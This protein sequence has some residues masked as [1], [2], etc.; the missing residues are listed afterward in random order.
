MNWFLIALIAPA[1]WSISN[2]I[3]KYLISRY[4]K[5]AAGALIIFSAL[6]SVLVVPVIYLFH[7]AVLAIAPYQ[8]L[9][10]VICGVLD[11]LAVTFY[12]YAL[13]KGEASVVVPLFQLIPILAF[14][15]AYFFLGEQLT[16]IQLLGAALVIIGSIVLSLDLQ[17]RLP[18][19]RGRVVA[20]MLLSSLFIAISALVFKAVAI[21][22]NFWTTSFWNYIGLIITGLIFLIFVPSYRKEFIQACR[23]SSKAVI[24][25]NILNEIVNVVASLVMRFASLLAPLAL[26]ATVSNGFQSVFVFLIGIIITLW[27]PKLGQENLHWKSLLQKA[28]TIAIMV[29]GTYFFNQ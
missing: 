17:N 11:I 29:I 12:L 7:P 13:Q 25:I 6:I 28:L 19:L 21:E 14:I 3:D 10:V 2:H 18:K 16:Q 5:G 9:L 8:A 27:W 4:F 23:T 15:L 1:L 24:G 20:L 22:V 26:V